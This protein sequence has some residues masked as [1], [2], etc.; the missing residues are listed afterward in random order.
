M[1]KFTL[2]VLSLIL[3]TIASYAQQV[4]GKVI[5]ATTKEP[6]PYASILINNEERAISNAEGI[7]SISEHESGTITVMYLGFEA[8]SFTVQELK[9]RNYVVAL[10]EVIYALDD[11]L[12]GKNTTNP[13]ELL[14]KVKA[15]AVKNYNHASLYST[16]NF[17]RKTIYF[18]PKTMEIEITKSTGFSNKQLKDSN[19][20]LDSLATTIMK[21]APTKEYIDLLSTL[22][23][24]GKESKISIDKGTVLRDDQR[25]NSVDKIQTNALTIILKHL[26]TTKYYKV[27]SG[28]FTAEDSLSLASMRKKAKT[29]G[30]VTGIKSGELN[31]IQ[32]ATTKLQGDFDFISDPEAYSYTINEVKM[33]GDD[34]VYVVSFVPKKGR[35]KYVGRLF[36]NEEDYAVTR[37]EYKL[38]DGKKGQSFNMKLLLGVKASQL[39][40]SGVLL[41]A[42]NGV[43]NTY[44]PKYISTEAEQY[45]YIHRPLKFIELTDS[46]KDKVAFDLKVEGNSVDH[47]E[48]L[49]LELQPLTADAFKATKEAKQYDYIKLKQYNP[50]LWRGSYSI[51]PLQE[52]KQFKVLD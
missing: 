12:V 46:S 33:M 10:P 19:R 32:Q 49:N 50:E 14:Q 23:V 6:L 43:T 18:K 2:T 17:S 11:T 37:L 9:N 13:M 48:L 31:K 26:D 5:D 44:V 8:Q 29:K 38:A 3:F 41:Y 47:Y 27:K 22:H 35:A 34:W 15:N 7:F 40:D 30:N 28:L 36:I 51:E 1:V 42:K 52:M 4:S 39:R 16:T 20:Q 25:S 21:Q 24:N 45:M